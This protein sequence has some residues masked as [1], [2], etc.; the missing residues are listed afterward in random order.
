MRLSGSRSQRTRPWRVGFSAP[1]LPPRAPRPKS[2]RAHARAQGARPCPRLVKV[3][4]GKEGT[5]PQEERGPRGTAAP[6]KV[7]N[8]KARTR[9]GVRSRPWVLGAQRRAEGA[10]L[11]RAENARQMDSTARALTMWSGGGGQG[12]GGGGEVRSNTP[13]S[14]CLQPSR[15]TSWDRAMSI[16]LQLLPKH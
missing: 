15:L 9:P 6:V 4:N 3:V 8:G 11:N 14:S 13:I 16:P 2:P 7:V 1:A 12:A 5:G 10:R